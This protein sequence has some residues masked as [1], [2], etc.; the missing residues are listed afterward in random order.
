MSFDYNAFH[1]K[2]TDA[3]AADYPSTDQRFSFAQKVAPTLVSPYVL[4]LPVDARTQAEAVVRA[5]FALRSL[6]SWQAHA[7][8]QEPTLM[9]P[10]NTSAL[11]SY[12]FHIDT[13]GALRLIEINTNASLSLIVDQ[14]HRFQSVPNAFSENF[15]DEIL[16]TFAREHKDAGGREEPNSI[17]IVDVKPREQRLFIEF[18]MYQELFASRGWSADF[19]DS[20]ELTCDGGALRS[21]RGAIDLVYNRD[22]DFYFTHSPSLDQAMRHKCA[23]ITPHPYEYRLLADK[24]RLLELSNAIPEELSPEHRAAIE[25]TLIR[26]IEVNKVDADWMWSQR[27]KWFF[28]PRRSHGGKAV[29]RGSSMSRGTFAEIL[30]GDYLAQEMVPP[31]TVKYETEDDELKY[32]LRFYVYRDKIQLACARLYRGQMTN[33]QSL[34]GGVAPIRWTS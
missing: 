29:Y 16:E 24:D 22:T 13:T 12:D 10:G 18:A 31:P 5:F 30:Q 20:S 34:G 2:F 9:N 26:T 3:C 19:F 1:R 17:A 8:T 11:M 27:K 33:A 14:L 23:T 28:K 7:V 25:R 21:P 15:R 32:D 4:D 6:P